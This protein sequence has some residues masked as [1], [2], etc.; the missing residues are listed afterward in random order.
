M[1]NSKN[2]EKILKIKENIN[3]LKNAK[4]KYLLIF[5]IFHKKSRKIPGKN[6]NQPNLQKTKKSPPKKQHPNFF[7]LEST[8]IENKNV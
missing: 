3:L 4:L 5:E 8:Q 7:Q 6:P 2:L 1:G